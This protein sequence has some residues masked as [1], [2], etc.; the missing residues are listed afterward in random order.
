M[1]VMG[2]TVGGGAGGLAAIVTAMATGASTA[3]AGMSRVTPVEGEETVPPVASTTVPP[4]TSCWKVATA[5]RA[6]SAVIT[7]TPGPAQSL[8][9]PAK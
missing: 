5:T 3:V 2:N 4:A 7:Q 9:Q 1:G 8:D 6:L